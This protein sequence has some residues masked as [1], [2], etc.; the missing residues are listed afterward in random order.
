MAFDTRLIELRGEAQEFVTCEEPNGARFSVG[1]HIRDR[2]ERL[3]SDSSRGPILGDEGF[4]M[5]RT[6][7]GFE[8]VAHRHLRE[9]LDLP[10]VP[11]GWDA[12]VEL[13][14]WD[15]CLLDAENRRANPTGHRH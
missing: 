4:H 7:R 1:N 13:G 5:G 12:M 14:E 9:G 8:Q 10:L 15:E 11:E 2:A 6:E 3:S